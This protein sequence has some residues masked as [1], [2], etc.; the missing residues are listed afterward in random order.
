MASENYNDQRGKLVRMKSENLPDI[1]H[2]LIDS[3]IDFNLLDCV[4][5]EVFLTVI[6]SKLGG[7]KTLSTSMLRTLGLFARQLKISRS[8]L[9]IHSQLLLQNCDFDSVDKI[10]GLALPLLN[11][12]KLFVFQYDDIGDLVVVF[13]NDKSTIG[14]RISVRTSIEGDCFNGKVV[15]NA[16]NSH[17]RSFLHSNN[18]SVRGL[19]SQS[20][21]CFPIIYD[22]AVYGVI[23]AYNKIS[24]DSYS[25]G[26]TRSNL[27]LT[28]DKFDE[29]NIS[30]I[31]AYIAFV[32][33]QA[34]TNR[35]SVARSADQ[36]G[37]YQELAFRLESLVATLPAG[38]TLDIL[39]KWIIDDAYFKLK[40]EKIS[41]FTFNDKI[42]KLDCII[43]RDIKGFLISTNS[44]I[45]GSVYQNKQT[46]NIDNASSDP[47]FFGVVDNTIGFVTRNVL[48]AP[49]IAE[50]GTV[51][52]V[53]QAVNKRGHTSFS[54][55]DEEYLSSIS[56]SA[57]E[58]LLALP[59]LESSSLNT[60]NPVSSLL[61]LMNDLM[62]ASSLS[63]V[64]REV[65][66]IALSMNYFHCARL[67]AVV[68][69]GT[70][71]HVMLSHLNPSESELVFAPACIAESFH[72]KG[73]VEVSLTETSG[74]PTKLLNCLP[75]VHT[76]WICP[77]IYDSKTPAVES[78][79]RML[80]LILA[81]TS[82]AEAPL[83]S[84]AK[85]NSRF[86]AELA[87]RAVNNVISLVGDSSSNDKLN[88][89]ENSAG[90]Y[91]ISKYLPLYTSDYTFI[92]DTKGFLITSSRPLSHLL[93]ATP[94][95]ESRAEEFGMHYS[96]WLNESHSSSLFTD[97]GHVLASGSPRLCFNLSSRLFTSA[98][99][100]GTLISYRAMAVSADGAMLE[101]EEK[102]NIQN[103]AAVIV[104]IFVNNFSNDDYVNIDQSGAVTGD[105]D[106]DS[107]SSVGS[108]NSVTTVPALLSSEEF[109]F[110]GIFQDD[111][112]VLIYNELPSLLN[113]IGTLFRSLFDFT[114]L[115][116]NLSSLSHYFYEVAYKYHDN[117][118]HNFQHA[119]A[120]THFSYILIKAVKASEFL[121]PLQIFAIMISAVVHDVDHPG[122]TNL[123]EINSSSPL[124]LTYND[125][126]VLENH[127]CS[128][129]FQLMRKPNC[130]FIRDMPVDAYNELRKTMISCIMAT[131]MS[132]HFQL[133]DE[134]K[135]KAVNGLKLNDAADS[136]FACKILLHAA[137]LSNPVR[138][139]ELTRSW[140]IRISEEFNAQVEKEKRLG[141]PVLGFMM[142]PD[143]IAL[144]KNEIGFTYHVVAPMWRSL[145][146][147]YPNVQFLVEKLDKNIANWK[148]FL[149]DA[150][151]KTHKD[152]A[153]GVV[154]QII[155]K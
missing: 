121:S 74:L 9:A 40:A 57:T 47:R 31:A 109:H 142:I 48:C 41:L 77:I 153:T 85:T 87:Q 13:S 118:F 89:S 122:N 155:S 49:L 123:F 27:P 58:V 112:N 88:P 64:S 128:T 19:K 107:V 134:T 71:G 65:E 141:L 98:R 61:S 91:L 54:N 51:L 29:M 26:T 103:M 62:K 104:M 18:F 110:D 17:R 82:I 36:N 33:K 116:I 11:S 92:L 39:F 146:D 34:K 20:V 76:A 125:Q 150:E 135:A 149:E 83:S 63:D 144:C 140:A 145:S 105:D 81:N 139:F 15:K 79:P 73:C 3:D 22:G 44:G 23:G 136:I 16:I 69:E 5:V 1:V 4:D 35:S 106:S 95:D 133:V 137:D 86:I 93:D 94:M 7:R 114:S 102:E 143:E 70:G 99:P 148:K 117:P 115:S 38:G 100:E 55:Q 138:P 78:T 152:S 14:S 119:T 37:S 2:K 42:Q 111:F 151:N 127:H 101:S 72:S 67:F 130:Q 24:F 53:I 147:L 30:H 60:M 97:I 8:L 66:R 32:L 120:V 56:K 50:N 59:S 6:R 84:Y 113:I 68:D 90:Q 75:H 129:A 80:V 126:S 124:A 132:I 12:E 154:S 10:I 28:F 21:L 25:T 108:N 131:D 46:C 96:K 45:V 43:S 52:G